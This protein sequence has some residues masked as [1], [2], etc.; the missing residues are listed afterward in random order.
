MWL[1]PNFDLSVYKQIPG[2][3]RFPRNCAARDTQRLGYSPLL[4]LIFWQFLSRKSMAFSYQKIYQMTNAGSILYPTTYNKQRWKKVY[5][6]TV[7]ILVF[8]SNSRLATY[9]ISIN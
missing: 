4:F 2:A 3:K 5:Q 1:K 9:S 6:K 8:K 7:R